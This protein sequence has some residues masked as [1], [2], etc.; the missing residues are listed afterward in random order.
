MG[1]GTANGR[2][3]PAA[4]MWTAG[5]IAAIDW[6][7]DTF[8]LPRTV[9]VQDPQNIPAAAKAPDSV[10]LVPVTY[11]KPFDE[12]RASSHDREG[13]ARGVA[14]KMAVNLDITRLT[15]SDFKVHGHLGR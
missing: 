2:P 6:I 10:W 13:L 7:T 14:A 8:Q 3:N 4:P 1:C 12:F 9:L 15:S 11:H 5:P